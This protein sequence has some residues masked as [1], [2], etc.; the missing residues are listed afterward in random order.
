MGRIA[1][2]FALALA[3]GAMTASV[4]SA[5]GIPPGN[6]GADQYAEGVPG[7]DG[8]SPANGGSSDGGSEGTGETGGGLPSQV[9]NELE[10]SGSDGAAAVTALGSSTPEGTGGAGTGGAGTNGAGNKGP[11][12]VD[13]EAGSAIGAGE[14]DSDRGALGDLADAVVTGSDEGMGAV[15]PI[16]LAL[17]LLV[18]LTL[19][20]LRKRGQGDSPSSR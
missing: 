16:L 12:G 6:S 17:V 1:F 14:A 3:A 4:A 11:A 18:G 15:L 8:N 19:A 5:Q 9:V 7:A 13:A 2:V 10:E 20:F